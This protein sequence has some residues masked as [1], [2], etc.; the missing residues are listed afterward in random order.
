VGPKP[1][2]L[3][4][5]KRAN[6]VPSTALM[7]VV[8]WNTFAPATTDWLSMIFSSALNTPSWLKSTQASR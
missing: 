5:R 6:V 7:G 2:V 8:T 4:T 1:P 3:L